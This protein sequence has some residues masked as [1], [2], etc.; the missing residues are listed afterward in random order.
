MQLFYFEEKQKSTRRSFYDT[1]FSVSKQ[2]F[3]R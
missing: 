2:C 1:P 3:E